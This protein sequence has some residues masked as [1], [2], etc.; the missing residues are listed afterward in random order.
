MI[1]GYYFGTCLVYTVAQ[2]S[3]GADS[4]EPGM[5]KT[6]QRVSASNE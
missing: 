6:F 5:I 2:C 4:K 1:K 3:I